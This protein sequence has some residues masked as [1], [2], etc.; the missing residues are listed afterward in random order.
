MKLVRVRGHYMKR[1][2]KKVYVR[3]HTMRVVTSEE[4][5]RSG[6]RFK[7][8]AEEIAEEY[9]KKGYSRSAAM[10]IGRATAGKVYWRKYGKVKG[11]RILRR[12]R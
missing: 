6:E 5:G 11:K 10:R 2:G 4:R 3:P 12:E 8:L 7:K 1:N 9:M